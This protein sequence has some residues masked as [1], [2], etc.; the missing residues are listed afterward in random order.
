MSRY[1]TH[2]SGVRGRAGHIKKFQASL[3][4]DNTIILKPDGQSSIAG[5]YKKFINLQKITK[6]P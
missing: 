3:Q 5:F 2:K 4:K 6:E 1:Y